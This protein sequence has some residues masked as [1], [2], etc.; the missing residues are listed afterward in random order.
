MKR[1]ILS[2]ALT[3]MASGAFAQNSAFY[4]AQDKMNKGELTE[5]ASI[6]ESAL[7]NPKTSQF[8]K[9]YNIGGQIEQR[10]F[11]PE[12]MK[13][14]QSMP[15]DTTLF[16]THLDKSI[17]YF[18]KSEEA[19]RKPDEKGRVKADKVIA[20]QNKLAISQMLDYY[21]YAAMF[22]N[23]CNNKEKSIEYFQKYAEMPKNIVFSQ[24]ET[25]SIYQS[26]K[27]NYQQVRFNLAYLYYQSKD[28][29]KTIA[30]CDEALKDTMGTHDLY[31]MKL[32]AQGEMK[33][34]AAWVN[35]LLEASTRTGASNFQQTLLYYYM[36]NQKISE[37]EALAAKLVSDQPDNK[38]SWFMKGAIELNVKKDYAAARESFEKA[39]AIDPD[40]KDALFNMGTA[41]INDIYD[42]RVSGKFK[43]IG[44]NRR[45]EGKGQ[46]A[47]A[48]EKAIYDKELATVKGYYK[49]AKPYLEH[50]RELTPDEPKRW[51]SALQMV[52]SSLQMKEQ[53]KEMDDLLDAANKAGN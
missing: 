1:T 11:N 28:W 36:Q 9:I 43:Y 39:L 26:K 15:F 29:A 46:A 10:I 20:M 41:Y 37:A 50:L 2:I 40:Y 35:T 33:D 13:A 19:N 21:N 27:Q 34:S 22:M 14:A 49:K 8:A 25:D 18:T 12:L 23:A 7:A 17:E 47:Y 51:A 24:E 30:A 32:A 3:M 53:A 6:I 42:Q 44:T 52:Y 45:I 38:N 16:C 4:K 31:V 5:A 48:K